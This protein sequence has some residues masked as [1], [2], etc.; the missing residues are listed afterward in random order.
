MRISRRYCLLA[1]SS[2]EAMFTLGLKYLTS[3]TSGAPAA[4]SAGV[5]RWVCGG[6]QLGLR[7]SAAGPAGVSRCA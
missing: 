4:G 6:N 2:R 1:A 3:G 5:S 7:G